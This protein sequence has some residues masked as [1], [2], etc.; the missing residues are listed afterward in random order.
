MDAPGHLLPSTV[1]PQHSNAKES[2]HR[3]ELET[4]IFQLHHLFVRGIEEE[5][6][7]LVVGNGPGFFAIRP[8]GLAD[9]NS[10]RPK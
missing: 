10:V 5:D 6:M 4:R 8:D 3:R 7:G 1:L 9:E 2:H